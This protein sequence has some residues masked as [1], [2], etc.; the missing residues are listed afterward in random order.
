[1]YVQIIIIQKSINKQIGGE[2]EEGKRMSN[3][4]IKLKDSTSDIEILMNLFFEQAKMLR[5]K[6]LMRMFSNLNLN[7]DLFY[8]NGDILQ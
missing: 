2:R 1:M 4:K 7:I 6:K 3:L 8:K 5:D